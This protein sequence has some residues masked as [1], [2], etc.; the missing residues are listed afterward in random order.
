PVS[1]RSV[2]RGRAA[3]GCRACAPV[4]A[5]GCPAPTTS[6]P[7]DRP[8]AASWR[9]P[10]APP[11]RRPAHWRERHGSSA[12]ASWVQ[13]CSSTVDQLDAT[14]LGVRRFVAALHG[15]TLLA[16]ADRGDLVI[17]HTLQH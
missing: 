17:R 14:V 2:A 16:V 15:R 1:H 6:A 12:G 4:A 11:P 9:N 13:L 8:P 3:A 7:P 5:A 10:T